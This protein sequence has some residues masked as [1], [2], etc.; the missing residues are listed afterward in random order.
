[1]GCFSPRLIHLQAFIMGC[2]QVILG[3]SQWDQTRNTE[4]ILRWTRKNGNDDHAKEIEMAWMCA[5]NGGLSSA[6]VPSCGLTHTHKHTHKH[7]HTHTRTHECTQARTHINTHTHTHAQTHT[8]IHIHTQTHIQIYFK[9]GPLQS[10]CAMFF[11]V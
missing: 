11:S 9:A 2:L 4:L 8:H 10:A 5:K 6:Q 1:M 3:V 7:T